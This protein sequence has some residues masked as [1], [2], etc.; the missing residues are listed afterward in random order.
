MNLSPDVI[1]T[2]DISAQGLS[3]EVFANQKNGLGILGVLGAVLA[4]QSNPKLSDD[5]HLELGKAL[6]RQRIQQG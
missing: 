3:A 1:G 5:A 2:I 6:I 4:E